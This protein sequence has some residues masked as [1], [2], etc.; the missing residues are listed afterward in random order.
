MELGQVSI[1]A[2][3]VVVAALTAVV[4]VGC[5]DDDGG[6][7]SN[8]N[9]V[10]PSSMTTSPSGGMALATS[11]ADPEREPEPELEPEPDPEPQGHPDLVVAPPSVSDSSPA[12]GSTFT[13]SAT[14]RN[15]GEGAAPAT[16]LRYYR[17]AD[18]TIT[19]TDTEEGS[20]AIATL[21]ASAS[22]SGSAEITAPSTPGMYYYGACVAAGD[23]E[24]N[25]TNNCSAS[26][27]V[28][29]QEE[30]TEDSGQPDLVVGSPSVSDTG[31][32]VGAKF[33]L[34]ATVRNDGEGAAAATTLHYYR[35]TD[36][37][38]TTSDTVEGTDAVAALGDSGSVSASMEVAAPATAGTYYFGACVDPVEDESDTSN[39]CSSSVRVDVEVLPPDLE[40]G[41]PTVSDSSPTEGGSFTLSATVSNTGEGESVATTLRYYRSTDATISTSDAQVGTD[42][43]EALAAAGSKSESVD[44]TAPSTAGTYYYGACVDA[45]TGESDTTD[46][47]SSSVQVDVSAETRVVQRASRVEISPSSLSFDEV[48]DTGTLTAT[49]YDEANNVMSP[50]SWG[51]GSGDREVATVDGNSGSGLSATVRAIGE[52]TTTISLGVN[53]TATGT[54][55]VTVTLSDARVE[56][57]P[58]TLTFEALGDTK[59]ATV[60]V[61]DS[62]GD[63]D[64]DAKFSY[65]GHF[66][67]C[68]IPNIAD[69]PKSVGITV[70]D[71]GLE[72]TA[73]GPGRGQYTISSEGAESA[74]LL[75]DVYM[76]PASL[77]VSP[78]SATLAVDGTTTLRATIKD[79]NGN[80]IHVS[81]GDGRG[82]LVVY[83]TTSDSAVATVDGAAGDGQGATATITG[84]APGTATITGRHGGSGGI[85]ATAT[86][87]VEE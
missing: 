43:V 9:P 6:N 13:L 77:E 59:T 46:N 85:A 69:P 29:V 78:S 11:V 42:A 67:P 36:A 87:T 58:G 24:S 37:T 4:T 68:C 28:D 27:A 20:D 47:C 35:S 25:T 3:L 57:S 48:G 75:V 82:G 14:V 19:P 62:N 32:S 84:V 2:R 54:A 72:I 40:V 86:I 83:W 51:W 12:V 64:E 33:T 1:A 80:S 73:E 74:I 22:V 49:V 71:G 70:V 21:A 23:G 18:A 65:F 5:S 44:L 10:A 79:A 60:R 41:T 31:P 7:R 15:D 30:A 56:V 8:R 45:V 76:N 26:V 53:G 81:E 39:N 63:E 55:T 16:M 61:L 50:T 38:I 52:G 17:S 66:S 34:S